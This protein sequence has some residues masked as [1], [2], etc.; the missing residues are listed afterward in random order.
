VLINLTTNREERAVVND[1]KPFLFDPE[2]TD[3]EEVARRDLEEFVVQEV[4]EHRGPPTRRAS[5][6]FRVRWEG[7]PAESDSWESYANLRETAALHRYLLSHG[8]AT[9]VPEQ[10]REPAASRK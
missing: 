7:Y 4:L 9:L 2:I 6:T 1:L 10:F 8:M 3:P 5:M